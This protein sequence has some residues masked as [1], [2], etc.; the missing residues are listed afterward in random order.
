MALPLLSTQPK[1]K[2]HILAVDLGLRFSKAVHVQRRGSIYHIAAYAIQDAPIYDKN[3]SAELMAEHLKAVLGPLGGRCKQV[4]L[5]VGVNDAFVRQ[6]ELPLIPVPDMR[7]MLKFNARNYL[8]QDYPDHV[9]DCHILPP[10]GGAPADQAKPAQRSRVLVGGAKQQYVDMLQ[11]ATKAA[12]YVAD[13]VVPGLIGPVNAFEMAQPQE[14]TNE[15]VALVDIGFKSTVICILLQGELA[16]TRVVSIG[17]DKLT[18]GV[19][20]ALGVSYAEAEGIKVGLPE[21]VQ[22]VMQAL[23]MPLGRELRASIDFFEH[24]HDR[25]VAQIFV[26]GGASRSEFIVQTIQAELMVPCKGWNPLGPFQLSLPPQQVGEVEQVA[27][28]LSVAVGA[29]LGAF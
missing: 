10:R 7:M 3:L 28:Q 2:D 18:T 22:S 19:A 27:S 24:Q 20:E 11:S 13:Q 29:A 14:F 4:V 5:A 23:L 21:E 25:Q 26:A 17:G 16:M 8:Q 12:G 1:K 6:A 15:V 9:F